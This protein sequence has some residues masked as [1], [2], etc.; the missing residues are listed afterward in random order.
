[1]NPGV[2]MLATLLDT[3][4]RLRENANRPD[5]LL[6]SAWNMVFSSGYGLTRLT[7]DRRISERTG[8]A[9]VWTV[10]TGPLVVN[11]TAATSPTDRV[12]L[13]LTSTVLPSSA[14]AWVAEPMLN[15]PSV[16]PLV[17]RDCSRLEN[18]ASWARN[19]RLSSGS[20][21]SWNWSWD[22]NRRMKSSCWMV[23]RSFR[24]ASCALMTPPMASTG[25]G[26]LPLAVLRARKRR[27]PDGPAVD[28]DAGNCRHVAAQLATQDVGEAGLAIRL[29]R[30]IAQPD[31]GP[32]AAWRPPE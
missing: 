8:P 11:W 29:D 15:R 16:L 26:V 21:G 9:V 3:V 27:G 25:I 30:E 32:V 12:P 28:D 5:R 19:S 4:S 7:C 17:C 1:R 23:V 20:S 24:V 31:A 13:L 14:K 6:K 22:R 2:F 18:C 10:S